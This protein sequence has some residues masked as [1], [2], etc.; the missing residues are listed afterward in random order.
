MIKAILVDDEEM[1]LDVLDILL[2]EIGGVSVLGKFQRADEAIE[3]VERLQPDLI[4][5][6]IE[7]PGLNGLVAAE[8]LQSRYKDAEIIFVTAYK[9][10][11][12][13][14]FDVHARGYLLKPVSKERLAKQLS[15]YRPYSPAPAQ[16]V[17]SDADAAERE[18]EARGSAGDQPLKLY[19]LGS[20]ELFTGD[21]ELLTWRTR[22]TKELF[23]FLWHHD[24]MPVHRHHI[25]DALW[26][27]L[28]ADRAQALFHTTMYHLRHTLKTAG[29]PEM[30]VFADERYMMRTQ[31][32]DSDV[33]RLEA[34]LSEGREAESEELLALYRGDYLET[35]HYPWVEAR[36]DELR[37]AYVQALEQMLTQE[38]GLR[39]EALLRKLIELEPYAHMHVYRLLLHL[40]AAGNGGAVLKVIDQLHHQVKEE[41]GPEITPAM[42]VLIKRY[43]GKK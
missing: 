20:L 38:Q 41:M 43:T 3:Q 32:I 12:L 18:G 17:S 35:E 7:M 6:D 30:V 9:E 24:G 15:H 22:K 8:R 33:S 23:A 13:H 27:E 39:R 11:G 14:A 19:A 10:Y 1:A 4:F 40:D 28:S 36:R 16:A 42:E 25:L 29:F 21:G 5:L 37:T 34:K 26:P 31:S 2:R